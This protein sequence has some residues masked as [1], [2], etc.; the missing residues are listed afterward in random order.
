MANKLTPGEL[1]PETAQGK[2]QPFEGSMAEAIEDA[3]NALLPSDQRFDVND[4]SQRARERRTLF[5][6]IAQGVV[7]HLKDNAAAFE[8]THTTGQ[9]E[10]HKLEV[11]T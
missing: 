6:S 2:P 3:L 7:K 8:V 5:V 4:N 11:K 1:G 10:T 9:A